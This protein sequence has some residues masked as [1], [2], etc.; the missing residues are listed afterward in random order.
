MTLKPALALALA[1]CLAACGRNDPVADQPTNLA[2]DAT[3]SASAPPAE[4]RAAA[5]AGEGAIPARFHGR[6]GRTADD[7]AASRDVAEGLL[8][9]TADGL[10]FYESVARP[11]GDIETVGNSFSA[12]FSFS[13]EG[14]TW[15]RREVLILEDGKLVRTSG[16]SADGVSYVRC[17]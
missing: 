3:E 2:R 14:E 16:E 13:G 6:W 17:R 5:G 4:R 12:Q 10:R 15:T 9:I 7:C 1:A 8:T 11:A